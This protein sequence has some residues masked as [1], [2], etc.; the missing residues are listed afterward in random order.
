MKIY[1][2]TF[3]IGVGYA[4]STIDFYKTPNHWILNEKVNSVSKILCKIYE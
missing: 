4:Q 2:Y 1:K 3:I